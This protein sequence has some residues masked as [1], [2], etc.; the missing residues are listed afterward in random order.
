MAQVLAQVKRE[1][2]PDAV[3]LHTRSFKQGGIFGFGARQVV[4]VTAGNGKEVGA[5][6]RRQAP[7]RPAARPVETS[8]PSGSSA[9][10][11]AGDLIRRT[12]AAARAELAQAASPAAVMPPTVPAATFETSAATAL[13][14]P[15]TRPGL[16]VWENSGN[17]AADR[18]A[19]ATAI[20]TIA[21]PATASANVE[22]VEEMRL[23]SQMVG[24]MMRRQQRETA[25][26]HIPEKLFDSYMSLL[27]QEVTEELAEQVIQEVHQLLDESELDDPDK[28]REAVRRAVAKLVPIDDSAGKLEPTPDGRP[29][30]IALV[31]PTGVGKTTT[32]AKLAATFKLKHKKNVGLIT[33]D[34]YRIAAVEQLRTY[35]NIVKVPLHVVLSPEDMTR[36][37]RK[38]A[39]CDVILI[40]TAG[41]SQRDDPKLEQL[42]QFIKAA[43]PHEVHLVL[44][45]TCTQPVLLE[46]IRKFSRIATDRII[47]TKLDEAV[48]FG[49]LLNVTRQVRKRLS[50]VTTGQ[51]VPHE[52]EPG[53]SERLAA[54]VMGEAAL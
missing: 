38:L 8:S 24:K 37:I 44:A 43:D 45:S 28:V 9:P 20:A 26:A 19:A 11:T 15:P 3:I 25:A 32:I 46:T 12:Y 14:M 16:P 18:A 49:V 35:A 5:M 39:G 41:R 54:L 53:Q 1:L 47:F 6:R 17:V 48:T 23:V 7:R 22:L 10:G 36:A 34:T 21:P 13:R 51:E 52:I 29:R 42:A 30:I 2:G 50:F 27:K 33:I 4:E 40:D 31:G